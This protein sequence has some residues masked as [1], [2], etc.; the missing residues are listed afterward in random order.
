MKRIAQNFKFYVFSTTLSWGQRVLFSA[1]VK[2]KMLFRV[3]NFIFLFYMQAKPVHLKRL[4]SFH[5]NLQPKRYR[6][7]TFSRFAVVARGKPCT[8]LVPKSMVLQRA[9]YRFER[10]G[11][12]SHFLLGPQLKNGTAKPELNGFSGMKGCM[13]LLP[14]NCQKTNTEK[15]IIP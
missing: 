14:E 6:S 8:K 2:K 1:F 12:E 9:A 15:K 3:D 5:T 11:F 13:W 7:S 4:S 10:E